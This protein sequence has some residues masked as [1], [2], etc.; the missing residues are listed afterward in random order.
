LQ[1][2]AAD[3]Q[4]DIDALR[5]K[6]SFEEGERNAR[7]REVLENEKRTRLLAEMEVAR[8]KQ[9]AERESNL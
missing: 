4:S 7:K 9:F 8:E 6:R 1:E 2:K 5:A 3:R